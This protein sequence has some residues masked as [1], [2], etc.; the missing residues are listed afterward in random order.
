[1]SLGKLFKRMTTVPNQVTGNIA[2]W[3]VG[4]TAIVVAARKI[5]ALIGV[6]SELGACDF[7]GSTL[8]WLETVRV[9][10]TD[11]GVPTK[12]YC[13]CQLRR[14]RRDPG[15]T[16]NKLDEVLALLRKLEA[17]GAW[18]PLAEGY[19]EAKRDYQAGA[20][21]QEDEKDEDDEND[22]T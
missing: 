21:W 10:T 8:H 7:C 2:G 14:K 16:Q 5:K 20:L 19:D 18:V 11:D 1:M 3:K 9:A 17:T 6:D 4:D 22:E 12:Y 15:V 13:A